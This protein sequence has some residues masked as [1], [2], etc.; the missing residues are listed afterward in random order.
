MRLGW[1]WSYLPRSSSRR[2]AGADGVPVGLAA[3][4]PSGRRAG[5]DAPTPNWNRGHRGVDL[6]GAVGPA[7]VRRRAGDRGVRGCAGRPAGRVARHIR[8]GCA[9]ATSRCRPRCGW[10]SS[11][12]STPRLGSLQ[13]GHPGCAAPACLHWGAMW[14]PAARA[15]YVDP[16]GLLASTRYASSRA[17]R[18]SA[19]CG[20]RHAASVPCTLAPT[21]L[22][23]TPA[24]AP[25]RARPAAGRR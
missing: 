5:F 2:P 6:A 12:T 1:R 8:A 20:G 21:Y 22:A 17:A 16:L 4:A 9:P 23:L 14:G 11:W 13:A 3:A 10:D 15:D 18:D 19:T 25:G 7:G 24:G